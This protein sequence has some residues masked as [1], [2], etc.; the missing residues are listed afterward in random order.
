MVG[1]FLLYFFASRLILR[2]RV[3]VIISK[4]EYTIHYLIVEVLV[5]EERMVHHLLTRF[6][7]SVVL[8]AKNQT[9]IYVF[10]VK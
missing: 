6:T 4:V 10:N 3:S 5:V 9:D 8:L 7:D 2:E 1:V